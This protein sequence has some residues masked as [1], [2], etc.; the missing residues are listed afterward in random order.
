MIQQI[1]LSANN[2]LN[3]RKIP[4]QPWLLSSPHRV[5]I[6]PVVETLKVGSWANLPSFP[7]TPER[8]VEPDPAFRIRAGPKKQLAEIFDLDYSLSYEVGRST[9][10]SK[11]S[12]RGPA[13]HGLA[14]LVGLHWPCRGASYCI[15]PGSV[16]KAQVRVG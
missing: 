4:L 16:W 10:R 5:R 12:L 6:I 7:S 14:S 3:T 2:I 9:L 1:T 13:I 15:Y 11:G 8:P